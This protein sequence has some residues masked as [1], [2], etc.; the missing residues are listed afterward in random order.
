MCKLPLK[1]L[2]K[3]DHIIE[4]NLSDEDFNIEKLSEELCLS[5]PH[6]YRKI[7]TTTSM[8]PS[9]YVCLKRLQ[10]AC[11]LL[12]QTDL[13]IQQIA[14]QVGFTS[15]AYFSRCFSNEFGCPPKKYRTENDR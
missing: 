3:L 9:Q 10:R 7:V 4:I 15:Q 6:T 2:E 13:P 5:Y 11:I 1:F 8:T 14:F 12:Q